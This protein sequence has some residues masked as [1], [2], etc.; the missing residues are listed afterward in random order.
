M[1][2]R[3]KVLC[4][5]RYYLLVLLVGMYAS[6][7]DFRQL[8]DIPRKTA[9]Q[10]DSGLITLFKVLQDQGRLSDGSQ[11][12]KIIE[13][14]HLDRATRH[15]LF[16][17]YIYACSKHNVQDRVWYYEGQARLLLATLFA[18]GMETQTA[19]LEF[20]C[21][22]RSFD[23]APVPKTLN[24][25]N[26]EVKL[27]QV[28]SDL[29]ISPYE[30]LARWTA[31]LEEKI[32]DDFTTTAYA[33]QYSFEAA[34]EVHQE[35]PCQMSKVSMLRLQTKLDCLYENVG[36]LHSLYLFH[37]YN[38]DS[39]SQ[40]FDDLGAVLKWHDNFDK[41][42]PRFVLWDAQLVVKK[43][44]LSI[45]SS[46][47]DYE[48]QYRTASEFRTIMS[49]R[50][51]FW[52]EDNTSR[53]EMKEIG[54]Q[55]GMDGKFANVLGKDV[56]VDE[57][58]GYFWFS[59]WES[60][61]MVFQNDLH[62]HDTSAYVQLSSGNADNIEPLFI[63]L[64]RWLQN[65]F[66]VA[67]LTEEQLGG[68]LMFTQDEVSGMLAA[69]ATGASG[70]TMPMKRNEAADLA[71][72]SIR[73]SLEAL[74]PGT[75]H[76]RLLGSCGSP[77]PSPLWE[78]GFGFLSDWLLRND[79]YLETKRHAL[80]AKLFS[81]RT[82]SRS[83]FSGLKLEDQ[84]H[85]IQAFI[86]FLP[87]LNAQAREIFK[88]SAIL[89]KILLANL[90]INAV[91]ASNGPLCDDTSEEFRDILTLCE[92]AR[93]ESRQAGE[94]YLESFNMTI[95]A[96]LFT[97]SAVK[98]R[99][100]AFLRFCR[101]VDDA[102]KLIERR[103]VGLKA[104]TGWDKVNKLLLSLQEIDWPGLANLGLL[105]A[106]HVPDTNQAL[107]DNLVWVMVQFSKSLGLGWLTWTN[108]MSSSD[109]DMQHMSLKS[110]E[111]IAMDS[112]SD[113]VFV[114]WIGPP[115]S[116][117]QSQS[118]RIVVS[119][120]GGPPRV[121]LVNLSWAQVE[122]II[123][124]FLKFDEDKLIDSEALRLLRKLNP[125]V[126][127]LSQLTSPGQVLVLCPFGRLH[128]LPMHALE[129]DGQPL[130]RRNPVVH[131]SSMTVLNVAFLKRKAYEERIAASQRPWKA[132]LFGAPPSADGKKALQALARKFASPARIE[133]EFTPSNFC[134]AVRDAD[135]L[136]FHG[137][138]S[139]D[140]QDPCDNGLIF[141]DD[142]R[143]TLRDVFDLSS[144]MTSDSPSFHATLLACGSGTSHKD[145]YTND[146]LGL[147]PAFLYA[148]ASSTL[149]TLW[150]FSDADA[151]L[152]SRA[153]YEAFDEP[154]D[155]QRCGADA[156]PRSRDQRIDLARATQRAVLAIMDAK[157]ELYHWGPFVLNGYWM[158]GVRGQ[159]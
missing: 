141:D 128:R 94:L 81:R 48:N 113:V 140:E 110:L 6:S 145:S 101:C 90:K 89:S 107:R 98:L 150:S 80:L 119:H 33:L 53:L 76:D 91:G 8:T 7:Y 46:M 75:L 144:T 83:L 32:A 24:R 30:K 132:A 157:P 13:C 129:V 23:R 41:T 158:C 15:K 4:I 115:R 57:Q 85:E 51:L 65:A 39:A 43:T 127:H 74:T 99:E 154:L 9:D 50:E 28:R 19:E 120:Q 12:L 31:L 82:S 136:H 155:S 49:E 18:K 108:T 151:A 40:R 130:I 64:F 35:N 134:S 79:R 149:S 60:S 100:D 68:I 117:S 77:T 103:R 88:F 17:D 42:Y 96:R 135:L 63:T 72:R 114:E 38:A 73:A 44:Q 92:S 62:G 5:R 124:E 54:P 10:E 139:P 133:D 34:V 16:S 3:T 111:A 137:H 55:S 27:A 97:F 125:L 147:V 121:K 1:L 67:E 36:D 148:G 102:E 37:A 138:G 112:G 29:E 156:A 11:L 93:E 61:L 84:I 122:T 153:F 22:T 95:L 152:F 21:A 78:K 66:E 118:P 142:C 126:E 143:L 109:Q 2:T 58:E 70:S 25:L 116:A 52:S 86:E 14:F 26:L 47:K 146:I 123:D 159:A 45:Y 20:N 69:S 59:E 106:S 56:K 131:S 105:V 104:L 71:R 87:K